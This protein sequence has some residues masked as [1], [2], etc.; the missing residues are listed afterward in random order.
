MWSPKSVDTQRISKSLTYFFADGLSP[1][2]NKL[3]K[4]SKTMLWENTEKKWR[5]QLRQVA[6]KSCGRFLTIPKSVVY[7]KSSGKVKSKRAALNFI[8]IDLIENH[9][10]CL[11][12]YRGMK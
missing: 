1:L 7:F 6:V 3:R 2:P 12:N 5:L 9:R 8:L 11:Y 4:D 10:Y